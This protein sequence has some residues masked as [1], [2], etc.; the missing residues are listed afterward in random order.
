MCSRFYL[1][2]S[3]AELKRKFKL[4]ERPD[5]V[6]RYNIAPTQ[7]APIVV[8]IARTMRLQIARWG[9][10]PPWSRDLS[11][12]GRMI[13]APIEEIEQRPAFQRP[14]HTQ[15][16]LVP[17]SGYYEWRLKEASR[18]PYRIG[19]R[20]GALF[21]F[22]GLWE[23]WSPEGGEPVETFTIITTRPNKLLSEVHDRMPAIVAPDDYR[24]WLTGAER[25]AKRLI[26]PYTGAMTLAPVSDR[27]NDIKQDDARLIAPLSG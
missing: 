24:R 26:L 16:C 4:D 20:A 6:R 8:A 3:A 25:I 21:A 13:N 12:G 9:L 17:A 10:V 15:R 23:R 19:L 27:V 7:P 5:P 14:F 22:A 11:L 2:A 1:I 18:Q